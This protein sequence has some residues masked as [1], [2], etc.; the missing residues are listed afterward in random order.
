MERT[1]DW[2]KYMD[3]AAE[4][5]AEGIVLLKNDHQALPLNAEKELAVFGRIQLHYYK[6][7]TGS[8][9]MVNVSKVIGIPEGLAMRGAKIYE[10][11]VHTYEA[12]EKE[13]PFDVGDGWGKEPW[14]QKEMLLEDEPVKQAGQAC[15][16]ALVIIGRTAGEDGDIGAEPGGYYLSEAE[17]EMLSKV[18]TYFR[19][20]VVLLNTA[21]VIDME[22]IDK[23]CPDAVLYGWQGGMMGG[24]GTADVLL[25]RVSPSGHLT[26]TIA[27]NLSDVPSDQNFGD[28]EQNIYQEDIYLGYRYFETFAKDR[29]R[30]PFGYGLSYADF[31]MTDGE[32]ICSGSDLLAKIKVSNT[33]H[34]AGKEVV[35]IYCKQP[36][37]KLGKP[38]KI[39]CGFQKTRTL[40]PGETEEISIE[41]SMEQLASYDD[42]GIT[43]NRF[44]L[45]CEAGEYEFY[46]GDNIR[47]VIRIGQFLLEETNVICQYESAMAP[48]IPFQRMKN[49]NGRLVYEEVPVSE[50]DEPARRENGLGQELEVTGDRG[51]RLADVVNQTHT[52]EEF[53]AQMSDEDLTC[54]V[55]GEGMS[56]PKVT[57][58]TASAF[59]GVTDHLMELGIPC[60]CCSD[61]PSGIRMDCGTKAFSLPNGTLLACTYNQTLQT[62]LFAYL[63]LEMAYHKVDCLLGPGMNLHRHPLNGRN[64]EYF[65]EDPLVTGKMASAQ[66]K[67]LHQAGVTGTIKHFCANNQEKGRHTI[68]SVVSER[69]LRELYLKGFEI[70]VKEGG[71]KTIMTTYG[72][73]N[74]LWTAGNYDL[75]TTI[76]RK[77][78]GF[79]GITMTD[80]WAAINRR[81]GEASRKDYPGMVIAQNDVYMP[82][83]S[84]LES[85]GCLM[86]ALES[87]DIKRFEL[88]RN[89]KNIIHFIM[90][91]HAMKRMMDQEEQITILNRTE[92]AEEGMEALETFDLDGAIEI[93]LSDVRTDPGS[94]YGFMLKITDTGFYRYTITASND[95]GPLAQIPVTVFCL[96]TACGTHTWSGTDNREVSYSGQCCMTSRYT[97][98]RLFF[99]IGGLK[100]KSIR[101]EFEKPR[102]RVQD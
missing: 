70:A 66:L 64:F 55:L 88:Q 11:L 41:I 26:D 15:E 2:Q 51:I 91:T 72:A 101:F 76:L 34:C 35:Q 82:C 3:K 96:G 37:G 77:Q 45:L 90:D 10:P 65:S 62:E 69:A 23:Y 98:I 42:S 97:A 36:Q 39:L 78:W 31:T 20:V 89:A 93:D 7:G 59:G 4:A 87:G 54:L 67:G 17:E 100:L 30:Y 63:G 68:D 18:R 73:V 33:G 44:C 79:Q 57:P 52:L 86:D 40:A 13:N 16:T 61:G 60:V 58:G 19:K 49:E 102:I 21:A 83:Q 85:H 12:W 14:S 84:A 92:E 99:A 53:I 95:Q 8:G 74:G 22:W 9:G 29:V 56:S 50:I 28:R 25:G 94:S 48:V 27:K 5:V 38:E 81:G 1:L 47:N 6:S 24:L 80:W 75:N 46:A 32:I 71:A 43:G